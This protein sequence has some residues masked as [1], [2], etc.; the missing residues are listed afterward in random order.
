MASLGTAINST[1]E[2]LMWIL[3]YADDTSLICDTAEKLREAVTVM[4]VTFLRWGLAISTQKG[5]VLAAMLQLKMQSQSSC[6]AGNSWRW[7]LSSNIWA[8]H[9]LHL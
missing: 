9:L 1:E 2:E 4:D 3:L 6:C 7:C 5:K 8:S